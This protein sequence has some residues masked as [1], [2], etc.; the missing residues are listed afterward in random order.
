MDIVVVIIIC[1]VL[2]SIFS[3]SLSKCDF[4]GKRGNLKTCNFE[5]TVHE[6]RIITYRLC[7]DCIERIEANKKFQQE[8]GHN[9]YDDYLPDDTDY[10]LPG[11]DDYTYYIDNDD[12]NRD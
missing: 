1:I 4:C 11:N 3:S 8:F 2:I 12:L 5:D 6:P 9:E 10:D 7:P